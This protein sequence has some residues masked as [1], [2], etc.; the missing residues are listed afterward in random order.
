M[1]NDEALN[2]PGLSEDDFLE[3]IQHSFDGIFLVGADGTALW[4]NPGCE[5]NYDLVAADMIGRPVRDL[6]EAGYFSPLV[7]PQVVATGR[8]VTTMQTTHKGKT[9][10]ATG[11]PLFDEAGQ[12][13]R[14]V[15]N[16]RD[17]TELL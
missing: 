13:R 8:R 9:I 10:M 4:A 11:I 16:S 7:S 1:K 5:R 12:V 2:R 6:E 3:I 15:I 17:M 14:V